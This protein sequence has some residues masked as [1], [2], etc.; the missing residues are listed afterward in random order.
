MAKKKAPKIIDVLTLEESLKLKAADLTHIEGKFLFRYHRNVQ[1]THGGM[2]RTIKQLER[3]RLKP[4][5][6]F[7]HFRRSVARLEKQ[8]NAALE[9]YAD[10]HLPMRWMRTVGVGIAQSVGIYSLIDIERCHK[11]SSLWRYSGYDPSVLKLT[12]KEAGEC[13]RYFR[14]LLP[15]VDYPDEATV[16]LVAKELNRGP[17]QLL[18]I[19]RVGTKRTSI[20]WPQ[21]YKALLSYPWNQELKEIL[22][23][24]GA[25]FRR[26]GR[27]LGL[28]IS[29]Y[30]SIYEWRKEYEVRRNEAGDYAEQAAYK[31]ESRS[32]KR[33]TIARRCYEEGKLP[34]A[35][36]DA[37]ARR[38]TVKIFLV[39]LHQVMF[40]ERYGKMPDKPYVLEILGKDME[41][42]CPRWPF[43]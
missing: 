34:P 25:M 19:T 9:I 42:S 23:R 21:L 30:R 43:K 11:V 5:E 4:P 35:H 39:H 28:Q 26:G 12:K 13:L 15:D 32:F 8:T 37:R 38:F 18:N 41:I 31:L 27:G 40:Y 1:V 6:L 29:P 20:T 16:R 24:V 2:V 33:D 14:E 10:Q 3:R 22:F 36:L 7:Q 17:K